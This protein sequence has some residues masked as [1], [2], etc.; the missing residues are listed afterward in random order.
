MQ[1]QEKSSDRKKIRTRRLFK[2]DPDA[3]E[4]MHRK[5]REGVAIVLFAMRRVE[6]RRG[7]RRAKQQLQLRD[8]R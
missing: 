6:W 4:A 5:A 8:Q 2:K 7:G 1:G 3:L